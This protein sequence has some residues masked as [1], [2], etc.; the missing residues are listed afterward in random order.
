MKK[1]IITCFVLFTS[2]VVAQAQTTDSSVVNYTGK[3][4]LALNVAFPGAEFEYGVS[5]HRSLVAELDL[6]NYGVSYRSYY[7]KEKREQAG[8]K[9]DEFTGGFFALSLRAPSHL[10]NPNTHLGISPTW[11]MQ[12][13][14]RIVHFN[15]EVGMLYGPNGYYF[16]EK[17]ALYPFLNFH[18]G[19]LFR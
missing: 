3:N 14:K 17:D 15:F 16:D 9:S 6:L 11:G 10:V 13:N 2:V 19:F 1:I 7:N 12:W 4:L 18:F 8:K 5:E